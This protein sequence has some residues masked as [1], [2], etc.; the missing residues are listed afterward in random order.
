MILGERFITVEF[1]R[2]GKW[3][4]L[5]SCAVFRRIWVATGRNEG[6]KKLNVSRAE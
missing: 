2:T 4:A 3:F 5:G 1:S 6:A